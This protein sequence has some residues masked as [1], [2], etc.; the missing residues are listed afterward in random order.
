MPFS[1]KQPS[2]F[3]PWK[4]RLVDWSCSN[5]KADS[6]IEP[7]SQR[8]TKKWQLFCAFF[9][10]RWVLSICLWSYEIV[11]AIGSQLWYEKGAER[12]TQRQ[13]ASQPFGKE[14]PT[15]LA[16]E[17]SWTYYIWYKNIASFSWSMEVRLFIR[18][19]LRENN[20]K[21][22]T[23]HT[24]GGQWSIWCLWYDTRHGCAF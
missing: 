13:N 7:L 6:L 1:V 11:K 4:S 17:R 14:N 10:V 5:P 3:W 8:L 16:V 20:S 19:G 21:S 12:G 15:E 24:R 9:G 2:T 22:C 23:F 18:W